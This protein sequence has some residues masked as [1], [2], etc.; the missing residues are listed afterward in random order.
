MLKSGP[1]IFLLRKFAYLFFVENWSKSP[2]NCDHNIDPWAF[3]W[4]EFW[5]W[6]TYVCTYV[7]ST[8][9]H[10]PAH[11]STNVILFGTFELALIRKD[12][13]YRN[14]SVFFKCYHPISWRDSISRPI[15]SVDAE[16]LPRYAAQRPILNFTPRS[17]LTLRGKVVPQEG[18]LCPTCEV[19]PWGWNSLFAPPFF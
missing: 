6:T 10:E 9:V 2:K 7:H 1:Y 18:N 19:I 17:K 13:A 15:N 3:S 11:L 5:S 8:Y 12:I 14:G 4:A 16:T